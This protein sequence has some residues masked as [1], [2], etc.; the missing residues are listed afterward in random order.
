E[1]S[2]AELLDRINDG[3]L[4]HFDEPMSFDESTV[5]K[6]LKEYI[7]LG[8]I[9]ARREGKRLLYSRSSDIEIPCD[10]DALHLF[11]EIAPCGVVGAFLLDKIEHNEHPF[12]LKHHY[13]TSSLDSDVLATLFLAMREKRAVTLLN[14]SRKREDAGRV[15]V[16]PLR[17]YI[18]VQN[19]RQHL[20]CYLS[21]KNC[22]K[23]FRIDYLSAV[24]LEERAERFDELRAYLN[25]MEENMFGVS[26]GSG[27]LGASPAERVSFTVRVE[28]GE[29]FIVNRLVR[30]RRCGRVERVDDST[31]RYSA[32]VYDLTELIPW[33]R[34]FIGRI[35][36]ISFS[37]RNI[38]KRFLDDLDAMYRLYGIKAGEG[39]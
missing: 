22:I 35:T 24:R 7:S 19:G 10:T 27:R 25:K 3:Y 33:I 5:R 16:V 17:V 36:E 30:E 14:K 37:N 4:S 1:Y 11:S 29:D 13:I 8:L 38:E 15:R 6:K 26:V 12:D 39:E 34:S 18:S 23:S 9:E 21:E 28:D 31:Y 20:L 32:E 2:L